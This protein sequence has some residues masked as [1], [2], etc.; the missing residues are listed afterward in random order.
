MDA[1]KALKRREYIIIL[2]ADK[3]NATV[4]MKKWEYDKKKERASC[5]WK[6]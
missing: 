3:G 1:L 2:K 5:M 4:V 6:L